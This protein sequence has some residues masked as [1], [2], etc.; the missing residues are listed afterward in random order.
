MTHTDRVVCSAENVQVI[1]T[2]AKWN[3]RSV[4]E[5]PQEARFYRNAWAWPDRPIGSLLHVYWV[6]GINATF[7]GISQDNGLLDGV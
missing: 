7:R 2:N 5:R 6:R 3:V 4:S 1:L